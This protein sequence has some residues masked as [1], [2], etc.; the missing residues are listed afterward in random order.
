MN[1][2]RIHLDRIHLD[3]DIIYNIYFYIDDYI[4]LDH[5]WYLSPTF[6]KMYMKKYNKSYT[7]KFNILRKDLFSFLSKLPDRYC[8]DSDVQF[9]ELVT[10]Q[11]LQSRDKM[12]LKND[13]T[14]IYNFYKKFF[15][16]YLTPDLFNEYIINVSKD[17]SSIIMLQGTKIID[18]IT[19]LCF[20]KNTVGL[21]CKYQNTLDALNIILKNYSKH[22]IFWVEC[23]I[24]YFKVIT[25]TK[26]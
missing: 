23:Q 17:L 10:T 9:Y 19:N 25:N 21:S 18:K 5:F 14:F 6:T 16:Y 12:I 1:P 22:D 13:I 15:T 11:C 20:N 24:E 4:T 26:Y 8:R 7:H 3:Y 2:N